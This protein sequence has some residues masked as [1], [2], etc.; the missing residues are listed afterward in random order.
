MSGR[1]IQE[2][3]MELTGSLTATLFRSGH[4]KIVG[5]VMMKWAISVL[6]GIEFYSLSALTLLLVHYH[7]QLLQ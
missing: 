2:H 7:I 3:Q 4:I 1:A 5:K 6:S